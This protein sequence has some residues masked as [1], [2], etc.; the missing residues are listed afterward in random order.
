MLTYVINA[1][2]NDGRTINPGK[3]FAIIMPNSVVEYC[4]MI[5]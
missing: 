2:T 4:F 3:M 5:A 1:L